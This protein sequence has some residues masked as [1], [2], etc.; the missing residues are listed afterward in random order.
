MA[1]YSSFTFDNMS[2]IGLDSCYTDQTSI[3]NASACTYQTQNFF[4]SDSSM[5]KPA[6]LALSQP[7]IMYQGGYLAAGGSNIDDLSNLQIGTIQTH[8]K[9]RIDL[10]HRPFLTVPFLG[11]GSVDAISESRMMQGDQIMN[12]KSIS[13]LSEKSYIKYHQTPL[14]PAIQQRINDTSLQLENVAHEGWI[15]GG[16]HSRELNRD[17]GK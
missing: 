7:G 12:K 6:D 8:P 2:R 10:F 1:T 16:I 9:A 4:A 15:R 5:K 14:L 11:R 13:G 17:T 3:Q